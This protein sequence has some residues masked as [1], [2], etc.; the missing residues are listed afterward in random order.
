MGPASLARCWQADNST[1][2]PQNFFGRGKGTEFFGIKGPGGSAAYR[3][4]KLL[5]GW[6]VS[7]IVS[8]TASCWVRLAEADTLVPIGAGLHLLVKSKV[9]AWPILAHWL[10]C[11][12]LTG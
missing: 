2:P 10:I 3:P 8:S 1:R 7:S 11:A 4:R 6:L 9:K 12:H 5:I